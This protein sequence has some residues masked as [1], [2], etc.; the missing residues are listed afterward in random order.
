MKKAL[1]LLLLLAFIVPPAVAQDEPIPPKRSKAAKV[2]LFAGFLPGWLNVDVNPI[3]D[4]IIGAKGAP[5]SDNGVLMLG[6]GGAIYVMVLPNVRIGGMGMS[7]GLKSTSLDGAGI[8]RD[9]ELHV[10][11]GGFTIEYVYTIVDRLDIAF[12]GMLGWGGMDLTMRMSNGGNNTWT[13]EQKY[14]S[15]GF[16]GTINNVSRTYSGSFFVWSPTVNVEYSLLSWL[17]L[18]AG[19][20]YVGM[21]FPSWTVDSEYDLLGVPSGVSGK[22]F[23]VNAGILVGTF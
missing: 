19:A 6:G 15:D 20:S 14:F 23:M 12:G 18:R 7:G 2:G 1:A 8:R 10:G 3:N 5:L 16:G 17:A 21:S 9:A 4:F 11:F 22:G 13:A